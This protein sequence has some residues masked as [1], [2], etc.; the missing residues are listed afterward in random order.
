MRI[1]WANPTVTTEA[2][3]SDTHRIGSPE[4][5]YFDASE[6]E[7]SDPASVS[8]S[9]QAGVPGDSNE[10]GHSAM[11]VSSQSL[12]NPP[13]RTVKR[14]SS[15]ANIK[16]PIVNKKSRNTAV[17][18]EPVKLDGEPKNFQLLKP[19]YRF[20]FPCNEV[21]TTF[22]LPTIP[23][24]P[25]IEVAN[26]PRLTL[27][28]GVFYE[29]VPH[30][31]QRGR[32]SKRSSY[33]MA[34]VVQKRHLNPHK[35]KPMIEDSNGKHY[36]PSDV[37]FFDEY[38]NNQ[39]KGVMYSSEEEHLYAIG[40]DLYKPYAIWLDEVER[41][42]KQEIFQWVRDIRRYERDLLVAAITHPGFPLPHD[43][44]LKA[45]VSSSIKV[46]EACVGTMQLDA[47]VVKA[48]GKNEAERWEGEI[49]ASSWWMND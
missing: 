15:V 33:A 2:T 39:Y 31:E 38:R 7:A 48:V 49:M 41:T 16:Q 40:H 21:P 28:L 12:L 25:S 44:D 29:H 46:H 13:G 22:S 37:H 42:T 8:I 10:V 19:Q 36:S 4:E 14:A 9:R 23:M 26:K 17:T 43:R 47:A 30:R 45:S 24:L 1:A 35:V 3:T 20:H 18:S 32:I 34:R 6:G 5:A 27:V 11:D